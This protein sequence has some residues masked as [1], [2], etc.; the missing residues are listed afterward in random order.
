[1][2][3]DE[4]NVTVYEVP[5]FVLE[6]LATYLVQ[7]GQIVGTNSVKPNRKWNFEI[8]LNRKALISVLKCLKARR[9][10]S[11]LIFLPRED[12]L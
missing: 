7:Y 4:E 1:M 12:G 9:D 10:R 2:R 3:V 11:P 8:I 5:H 6:H